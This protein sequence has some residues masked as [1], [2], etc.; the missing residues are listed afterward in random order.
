MAKLFLDVN[1]PWR[2]WN[3]VV[4]F[5]VMLAV[6]IASVFVIGLFGAQDSGML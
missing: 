3:A 2:W 6:T 5:A 1:F 4:P